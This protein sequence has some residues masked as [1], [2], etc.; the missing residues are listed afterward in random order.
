[1]MLSTHAGDYN[2]YSMC[3]DAFMRIHTYVYPFSTL[4]Y[5]AALA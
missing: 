4:V 5:A 3:A 2:V 1:M